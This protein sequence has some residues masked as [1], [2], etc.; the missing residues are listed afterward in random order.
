MVGEERRHGFDD[1]AETRAVLRSPP[2]REALTWVA[3]CVGSDVVEWNVLRGGMSSAM[4]ALAVGDQARTDL[5]LRCYVR[6]DLNERSRIWQ[7]ARRLRFVSWRP[8]TYQRR[9]SL[10]LPRGANVSAFR[11]LMTRLPGQ[12]VWDPR[13]VDRWLRRL[14]A[15][16]PAVHDAAFSDDDSVSQY[17]HYEQLSYEP[18]KWATRREVWE[19]AV[20][21]FH[22]P[23]LEDD[24]AFI[25]R[26]Y[27]PR[28]RAVE[29]G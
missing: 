7:S 10:P 20:E 8:P 11:L 27:P 14:A 2:T 13:S 25:H 22:G 9:A 29:P 1:D 28:Q 19:R 5:V 15:V 12:V 4:Y 24:R 23:I 26:D 3:A 21:L 16:L 18:P 17:L 6:A